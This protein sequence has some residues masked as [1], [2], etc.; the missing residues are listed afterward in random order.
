MEVRFTDSLF[1]ALFV[2]MLIMT[3]ILG[4]AFH[5]LGRPSFS[6]IYKLSGTILVNFQCNLTLKTSKF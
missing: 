3:C 4:F 2:N 5:N 1:G 6:A